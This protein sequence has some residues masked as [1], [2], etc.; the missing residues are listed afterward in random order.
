MIGAALRPWFAGAIDSHAVLGAR[1]LPALA[2]AGTLVAPALAAAAPTRYALIIGNNLG[3][4]QDAPLRY[5]EDDARKVHDVMRALGDV[6]PDRSELLLGEDADT[7]LRAVAR[8]NDE[9]RASPE[10]D[11][12][13][14]FVY[15]SGHADARGLHLG[16]TT[17]DLG[18]LER[19]IRG[20]SAGMRLLVLD[21]CRSGTITRV[22][23]ATAGPP[24]QARVRVRPA[25]QGVVFLTASAAG[26]DAQESDRLHGA[27]FTHYFVSGLLGAADSDGD[28]AIA[29]DEVYKY[30]YDGTLRATSKTFAGIQHP[31][32]AYEFRGQGEVVLTT[33]QAT[34][35]NHGALVLP[36]GRSFLVM[37][38]DADGP[39]IAEV[40]AQARAR[41]LVLRAGRY[42]LRGRGEDD[43]IE[44]N[45]SVAPGRTHALAASELQSFHYARMVRKGGSDRRL[46]HG[47]QVGYLLATP[48]DQGRLCHGVQVGYPL[49]ARHFS[50][51]PQV[52]WCRGGFTHS[53]LRATTDH[54]EL[55]ARLVHA[56]DLRGVSIDLGMHVG[57]GWLLQRF[58]TPGVAGPRTGFAGRFGAT[59]AL[60]VDLAAGVYLGLTL[61]GGFAVLR[62]DPGPRL[63]DAWTVVPSAQLVAGLGKRF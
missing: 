40:D 51:V 16:A 28:G 53:P 34:P 22:K 41:K 27:F 49:E 29:L 15:Y 37:Q 45:V 25:G 10:R 32:Y 39:V 5:A 46:A 55:G 58:E 56:W 2:L 20:S 57:L 26:E 38:G 30:A 11:E 17:L 43:L 21:A 48:L 3:D 6:A 60:T 31:T 24:L 23:G 9:I 52:S 7:V 62:R 63:A 59:T 47:P 1:V 44:G 36:A 42:Y 4:A 14:L 18:L 33:L 54:V 13:M 8:I 35:V 50:V 61:T 12:A 19:M